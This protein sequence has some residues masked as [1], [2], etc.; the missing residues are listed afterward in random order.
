M[1]LYFSCNQ[2]FHDILSRLLFAVNFCRRTKRI[3]LFDFQ[4]SCYKINFYKY[5]NFNLPNIICDT[6]KI[7]EI[8]EKEQYSVFPNCLNNKLMDVIN[9]LIKFNVKIIKKEFYFYNNIKLTLPN[10]NPDEKIVVYADS[11]NGNGYQL[12]LNNIM[13]KNNLIEYIKNRY[14]KIKKPYISIQIRNTDRKCDYKKIYEDNK[15]LIGNF[16][17]LHIATDDIKV[18]N[19][20]KSVNNNVINFTTFPDKKEY[21]NLHSSE[22]NPDIKIKD[23]ITDLVLVSLSEYFLT[24]SKGGFVKLLQKCY[25]NKKKIK[26]HFKLHP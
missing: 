4:N 22:I 6:N 2:G 15:D 25:Q 1:Y 21:L 3:I 8:L 11:G 10:F 20:F 26:N 19:Y 17:S 5:F 24:N 13:P 7:K 9:G 18:L 12:F 14:Q 23:L 16:K